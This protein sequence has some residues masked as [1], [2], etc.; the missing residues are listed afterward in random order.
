[1]PQLWGS[2]SLATVVAA[3]QAAV[4]VLPLLPHH[5]GS[6]GANTTAAVRIVDA[7]EPGWSYGLGCHGYCMGLPCALLY[8]YIP[9]S[10]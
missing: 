3:A 7:V 8:G 2:D 9:R 10:G 5:G 6:E 1:M 4:I